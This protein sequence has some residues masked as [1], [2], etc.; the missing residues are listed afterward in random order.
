MRDF[1][2]DAGPSVEPELSDSAQRI[3]F[4]STS[5]SCVYEL[6]NGDRNHNQLEERR[7]GTVVR[8]QTSSQAKR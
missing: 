8:I 5:A 1:P 3:P 2:S 7:T 6:I 4:S